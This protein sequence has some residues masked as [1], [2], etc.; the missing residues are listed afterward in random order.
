[1]IVL[2]VRKSLTQSLKILIDKSIVIILWSNRQHEICNPIN[3]LEQ[4]TKLSKIRTMLLEGRRTK[5]SIILLLHV[6]A[7]NRSM[8]YVCM[9]PLLLIKT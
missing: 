1:M 7:I 2:F 6:T 9:L 8:L 4:K 3:N 5:R